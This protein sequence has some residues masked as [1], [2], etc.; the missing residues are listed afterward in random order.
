LQA[1][2]RF[3]KFEPFRPQFWTGGW[4]LPTRKSDGSEKHIAISDFQEEILCCSRNS[5][6]QLYDPCVCAQR[7]RLALTIRVMEQ[8]DRVEIG[9]AQ[10]VVGNAR[11]CRDE[12]RARR[13]RCRSKDNRKS[14]RRSSRP[15]RFRPGPAMAP[16]RSP[17]VH[18]CPFDART[19]PAAAPKSWRSV[20]RWL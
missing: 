16:G 5:R 17:R 10:G 7:A 1:G 2:K 6:F 9:E 13:R 12:Q 8:P 14:R 19:F 3:W 18:G 20:R 11:G 4:R 15:R